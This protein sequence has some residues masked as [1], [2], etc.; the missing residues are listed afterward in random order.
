MKK[1]KTIKIIKRVGLRYA[2]AYRIRKKKK[3]I[4]K[5]IKVT[6]WYKILKMFILVNKAK[7]NLSF[8]FLRKYN[9]L[10]ECKASLDLIAKEYDNIKLWLTSQS[11]LEKYANH[12]YPPLLNPKKLDYT[13]IPAEVAWDLN[14]PLPPYYQFVFFGSHALW[15]FSAIPTSFSQLH[16]VPSLGLHAGTPLSHAWPQHLP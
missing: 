9:I 13:K 15:I 6:H 11:F 1:S 5:K 14:L 10:I 2:L 12:P 3:R 4:A 7:C 16:T 8:F